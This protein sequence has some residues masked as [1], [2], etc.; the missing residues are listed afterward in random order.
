MEYDTE[1]K[2]FEMIEQFV[3][4]QDQKVLEVGCGEGR[5]SKLLAHKSRKFIAIDPDE[6]SIEKA[7]SENANVDFR[8]GSGEALEFEDGSFPII[9]FTLS[10]HHQES[11]LAL[12]E[13]HRVLTANGQLIILEPLANGELT[14]IFNLFDDESE[15]ILDALNRL[16]NS[17]FE[18]ERKETFFTVM[19]F[20]DLDELCN[21]P[22]G[23]SKIQPEDRDLIIEILQQ[24]RAPVTS[25]KPIHLHDDSQIFSLRK[26]NL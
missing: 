7:K 2:A 18:I 12:K 3:A 23:R 1:N 8:I 6:Q 17:D 9:L 11:R 14:K 24:L 20:N 4:L 16:K 21:Y 13:A 15:R 10:L 5:M 19:T 25:S 26:K 22:F